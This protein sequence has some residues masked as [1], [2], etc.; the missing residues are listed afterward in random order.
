MFMFIALDPQYF[1]LVGPCLILGLIAQVWVSMAFSAG[2]KHATSISGAEAA[3]RILD[4]AGLVDVQIEQVA[5]KLTDH[6]DPSARVL[7]LSPEVYSGY[8]AS[9]IGVAAHEAGHALQ[10]AKHYAPLTIRNLVVPLAGFG[11]GAGIW[12]F[13]GGMVFSIGA[14]VLAGIILFSAVVFFQ[15]VNLPVEFNASTRAKAELANM[16][17]FSS[18]ALSSVNSV[19]TAAAMTY[20]A[21]T[22]QAIMTLVY[23]VMRSSSD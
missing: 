8:T 6:Y 19:L 9:A 21:A 13:I 17:I 22:L 7:R 1:L 20:V 10:H 5:G 15:V 3:R 2:Q 23:L 11:S 14:L 18:E 4:Q 12:M 16:G